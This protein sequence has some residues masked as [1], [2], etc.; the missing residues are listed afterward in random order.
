MEHKNDEDDSP[1]EFSFPMSKKEKRRH[2]DFESHIRSIIE[3]DEDCEGSAK[4]DRPSHPICVVQKLN[5]NEDDLNFS[6]IQAAFENMPEQKE[7]SSAKEQSPGLPTDISNAEAA[8]N[9]KKLNILSNNYRPTKTFK[10]GKLKKPQSQK[11]PTLNYPRDF[12]GVMKQQNAFSG[13]P[14]VDHPGYTHGPLLIPE[15]K[16]SFSSGQFYNNYERSTTS[17]GDSNNMMHRWESYPAMVTPYAQPGYNLYPNGYYH[18]V[19]LQPHSYSMQQAYIPRQANAPGYNEYMVPPGFSK[20]PPMAS[21]KN[22]L[23][24]VNNQDSYQNDSKISTWLL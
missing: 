18:Q 19:P 17:S 15:D 22:L 13:G 3:D 10:K 21:N 20:Q 1:Q 7:T 23:E 12:V 6:D 2:N 14:Y 9:K 5:S 4:A 8:L 16:D 11:E 24:P